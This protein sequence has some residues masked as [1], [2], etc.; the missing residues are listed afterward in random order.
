MWNMRAVSLTV[1]VGVA[2]LKRNEPWGNLFEAAED[3][4][5]KAKQGGRDRTVH[6]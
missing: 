3:A 2:G 1:S 6:R 5:R 4:C